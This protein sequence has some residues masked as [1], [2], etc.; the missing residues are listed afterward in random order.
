MPGDPLQRRAT[1]HRPATD[2]DMLVEIWTTLRPVRDDV[3]E[4]KQWRRDH[5]VLSERYMSRVDAM[6]NQDGAI[7]SLQ[8]W[9]DEMRGAWTG[10]KIG[11]SVIAS[12]S[13]LSVILEI[14]RLVGVLH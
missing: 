6:A 8:S 1:D 10:V 9:R 14:L 5:L 12:M 11:L 4:L 3:D 2:H 7:D 13:G